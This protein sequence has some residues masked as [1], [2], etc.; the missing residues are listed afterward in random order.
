MVDFTTELHDFADTAAFIANLDLVIGVDTAVVHLAGALGRKV[1]TLLPYSPDWRWL[2]NRDDSPWYPTMRLFRQ[3]G[4]GD[5]ATVVGN[6][7]ESLSAEGCRGQN[8]GEA[9]SGRA[10]A[11][12][13]GSA[14]RPEPDK[15]PRLDFVHRCR[16]LNHEVMGS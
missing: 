6:V 9:G 16:N 2:L 3:P 15:Q 13:S 7:V 12:R 5:W 8:P 14:A 4:P 11:L 1:W 10:G